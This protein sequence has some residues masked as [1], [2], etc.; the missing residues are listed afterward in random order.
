MVDVYTY[1]KR[2]A[3]ATFILLLVAS[4]FYLLGRHLYFFL[5][6]FAGILVAVM[7]CGLTDWVVYHVHLKRGWSL[8]LVVILF[9][10]I[11]AGAF[12]LVA[13]TVSDQFSQMRNAV[14][15]GLKQVQDWL[16]QYSW[17]EKLVQ[18]VPSDVSK[19]MPEQKSIFSQLSGFLSSTLSFL[20]DLLIV[21]VT[22][23]FFAA[24]PKL[25]T[26]GFTKLFPVRNRS[27]IGKVLNKCYQTLKMW[28]LGM[29]ISMVIVGVAVAI[30]FKL[31]GLPMAFALALIAFFCEFVPNI[32]PLLAGVPAVLTGLTQGGQTALYVLLIYSG[33][34]FL[35]SFLITP[36]IL[37]KAV[38]LP[39][40]VLLFVQVLFGIVQGALGLLMAAPILA[41]VIVIVRELWV[42][43]VLEA[44]PVDAAE[45]E[46][47]K[48]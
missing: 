27:R 6:V 41:V 14:P 34:Q 22:A 2:V 18:Q 19:L 12:M 11:I 42:K 1:A 26:G 45:T 31:I 48:S 33:I 4:G 40:A 16:S 24:N 17:G 44:D 36:L 7:F 30:G 13:P 39:P 35:E 37:K 47:R 3:I 43:D 23:L 15:Q 32:G 5:L 25:Y 46:I 21:L 8:L 38:D 10:G 28:L 9:F 29:L 20:A